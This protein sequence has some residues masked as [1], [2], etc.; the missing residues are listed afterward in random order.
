M[1]RQFTD[2]ALGLSLTVL[3]SV[4]DLVSFSGI[5]YSIYPPL[6]AAL[7][8]YSLGG[9]AISVGLGKVCHVLPPPPPPP[10]PLP[11]PTTPPH[12]PPTPTPTPPP[13]YTTLYSHPNIAV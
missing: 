2:A 9:T 1:C 12:H 4:I 6:F 8:A 13:Y 7:L 10:T 5:L 3:N 11:P